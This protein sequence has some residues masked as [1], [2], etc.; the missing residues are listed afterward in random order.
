M[1][2]SIAMMVVLISLIFLTACGGDAKPN[3]G[4]NNG[5]NTPINGSTIKA[6]NSNNTE[7]KQS[8]EASF[9]A[10]LSINLKSYQ[11]QLTESD[12]PALEVLQKNLTALVEHDHTLFQSGFV[13]QK[14][15]DAMDSYYGKQFEYK[16]IDIDS[17][18]SDLP[19]EHQLNITVI[20]Q[21]LDTTAGTIEDVKMLYAIRPND[22]G[23]WVIYTID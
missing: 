8:N 21:R 19:N 20:G 16:F 14:L 9:K 22:Q 3:E 4:P 2:K 10:E 15:A 13:N 18:D 7:T 1:L 11:D 5:T 23:E 17:I 12:L 6:E